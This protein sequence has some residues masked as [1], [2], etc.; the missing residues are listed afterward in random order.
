MVHKPDP[1]H[2]LWDILMAYGVRGLVTTTA[3]GVPGLVT[4]TAHVRI[5]RGLV[6]TTAH[7]HVVWGLV[8]TIGC[9]HGDRVVVWG[10]GRAVDRATT[11]EEPG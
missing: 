11:P 7:I 9:V 10:A 1:A 4:T 8:K 6:T 2:I 3:H 5:D